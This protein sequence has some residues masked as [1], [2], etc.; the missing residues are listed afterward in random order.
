[1]FSSFFFSSL[2]HRQKL[3]TRSSPFPPLPLVHLRDRRPEVVISHPPT[4]TSA[5]RPL[6]P[7]KHCLKIC[8]RFA[9]TYLPRLLS[10]PPQ[11]QSLEPYRFDWIL[12]MYSLSSILHCG[13]FAPLS[14]FP[15]CVSAAKTQFTD[16]CR[17]QSSEFCLSP[18]VCPPLS[19]IEGFR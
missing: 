5:S 12:G 15:P 3:P 18:P 16:H 4:P 17:Q 14:P 11:P 9:R 8:G 10:L 13:S 6:S 2:T 1:M 19:P 7:P